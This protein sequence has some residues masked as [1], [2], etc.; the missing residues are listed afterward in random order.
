MAAEQQRLAERVLLEGGADWQAVRS[1]GSIKLD[2]RL[3]LKARDGA[4]IGIAKRGVRHGPPDGIARLERDESFDPAAYYFRIAPLFETA[5]AH[6]AWINDMV[7][8]GIGHRQ[9]DGPR[10]SIFE[11]P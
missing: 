5:S 1:D 11:V 8:I 2:V 10:C 7:A 3:V 9:I 4:L 6:F